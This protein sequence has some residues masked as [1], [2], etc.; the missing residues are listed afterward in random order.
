MIVHFRGYTTVSDSSK[1][2]VYTLEICPNCELLK[3]YLKDQGAAFDE[4][5]MSGAEALTELRLNGVFVMEAPVLRV[6]NRFFTS[7]DIF[8]NGKV[9]EETVGPLC[10]GE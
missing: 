5:D 9:N 4:M 3:A 2:T 7:K 8:A 10:K 1:I 6:G